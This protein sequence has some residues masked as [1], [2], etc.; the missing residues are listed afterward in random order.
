MDSSWISGKCQRKCRAVSS[1]ISPEWASLSGFL[2][3]K[4][5][6]LP[7]THTHTHARARA[8]AHTHMYTR[9]C[10]CTRTHVHAHAH[11]H[12]HTCTR[13]L[14]RAHAHTHVRMLQVLVPSMCC[15]FSQG[16]LVSHPFPCCCLVTKLCPLI[17]ILMERFLMAL[18]GLTLSNSFLVNL[19]C[20]SERLAFYVFPPFNIKSKWK[21][22]NRTVLPLFFQLILYDCL[23]PP[24][25]GSPKPLAFHLY[26]YFS[27]TDLTAVEYFSNGWTLNGFV[28]FRLC[29]I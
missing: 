20:C 17:P 10:T 3:R 18:P 26:S 5:C 28:S 21:K 8:R 29:N 6:I 9:A 1:L 4:K 22:K 2:W 14:A 25:H 11:T 27:L 12:A 16:N 19:L 15:I 23:F 24:E 7:H 13:T